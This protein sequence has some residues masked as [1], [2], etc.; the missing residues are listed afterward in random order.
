M[1]RFRYLKSVRKTYEEQGAIY[2]LCATYRRQPKAVRE[3]I[4]R[5]CERVGGDLAP[6]LLCYLTTGADWISVC[7]RFNISSA[8]LERLR[9]AFY[10]AW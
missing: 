1:K 3:R 5:L 7:D 10:E 4:E 8:T 6:A 9:R 2:F